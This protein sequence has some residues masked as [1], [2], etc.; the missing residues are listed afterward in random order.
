VP[1]SENNMK[2]DR[3]NLELQ[4]LERK[5]RLLLSQYESI[6]KDNLELKQRNRQLEE[7]LKAREHQLTDFQNKFKISTIAKS[8]ESGEEEIKEVKQRI[9]DY[10]K[11]IDKCI[12]QL[13]K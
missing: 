8:I 2:R 13:S 1:L 6:K 9:N 10:I 7:Q 5:V 4:A 11:E 3:L 12:Y